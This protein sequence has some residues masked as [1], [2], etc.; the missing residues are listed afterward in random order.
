[1]LAKIDV[2]P[3]PPPHTHTHPHPRQV[4]ALLLKEYR[5]S[6]RGSPLMATWSYL[7]IW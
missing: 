7:K 3:P 5:D 2:P 1:M 4:A 6:F